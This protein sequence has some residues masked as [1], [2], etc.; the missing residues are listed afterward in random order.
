MSSLTYSAPSGPGTTSTGRPQRLPSAFW[1]PLTRVIAG[2]SVSLAP[3]QASHRMAGARGGCRSHDPCTA[4]T[5]PPV[6]GAGSRGHQTLSPSVPRQASRPSAADVPAGG[7]HGPA[8]DAES[9]RPAAIRVREYPVGSFAG[10]VLWLHRS[11][12]SF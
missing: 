6:H 11:L 8:V 4:T 2:M 5:A 1:N 9:G 7:Q 12:P 10:E 3:F